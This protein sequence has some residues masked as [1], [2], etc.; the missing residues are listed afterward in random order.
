MHA[1]KVHPLKRFIK[2]LEG[3]QRLLIL[4]PLDVDEQMIKRALKHSSPTLILY[5]DGGLIHK[6][7]IPFSKKRVTLSLGDGDSHLIREEL[8]IILPTKKDY[9]DLAFALSGLLKSKNFWKNITFLGFSSPDVEKRIDHLLFN[10][11]E[12]EKFVH[13]R[14]ISVI[15]DEQFLFFPSGKHSFKHQGTF[16]LI[17]IRPTLL[18]IS[19]NAEYKLNNW[20]ELKALH[21]KGLSNVANGLVSIQSTKPI[22]VYLAG[23]KTIS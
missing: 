21:S 9:S 4:G 14:A 5:I 6:N 19:G 1:S 22:I 8:S 20:T 2:L 17:A 7:K 13:K 10:L 18:K 15:L 12:I 11:G 3:H 23:R 16:S